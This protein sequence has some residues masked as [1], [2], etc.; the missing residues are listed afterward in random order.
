MFQFKILSNKL[1]ESNS[2]TTLWGSFNKSIDIFYAPGAKEL[3][4]IELLNNKWQHR[5]SKFVKLQEIIHL[6]KMI[7]INLMITCSNN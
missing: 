7:K 4:I 5:T 3:Q 1:S 6:I 2:E